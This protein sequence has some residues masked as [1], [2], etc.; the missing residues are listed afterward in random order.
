MPIAE[1]SAK[2]VAALPPGKR[3]W[4]APNLYADKAAQPG[5]WLLLYASPVKG[6]RVEMGLG[7]NRHHPAQTGEAGSR[8][9]PDTDCPRPVPA[10]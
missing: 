6:R 9:V 2:A 4:I 3:H 5:S 8:R 7:L 10:D 1:L